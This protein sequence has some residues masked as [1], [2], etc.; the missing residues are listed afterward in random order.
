MGRVSQPAGFLRIEVV[1]QPATRQERQ[2][3]PVEVTEGQLTHG[4]VVV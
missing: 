1:V 4:F 2:M 3:V